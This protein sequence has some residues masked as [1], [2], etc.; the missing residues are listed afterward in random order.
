M[1]IDHCITPPSSEKLFFSVRKELVPKTMGGWCTE[2][3]LRSL[4]SQW[5]IYIKPQPWRPRYL[6]RKGGWKIIKARDDGLASPLLD[7]HIIKENQ[8]V[9]ERA[10]PQGSGSP[11]RTQPGVKTENSVHRL[12]LY[13]ATD[14][15]ATGEDADRQA[16][17][18]YHTGQRTQRSYHL[19]PIL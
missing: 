16:P 15:K 14:K 18:S 7:E 1:L 13:L 3:D 10:C 11:A 8:P 19:H 4:N 9:G 6:L 5:G 17:V 2:R 12:M